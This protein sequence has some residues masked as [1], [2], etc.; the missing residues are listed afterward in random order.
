MEQGADPRLLTS[1]SAIIILG[2][3][4]KL[5]GPAAKLLGPAAKLLGPAAK[6]HGPA[7][8]LLGPEAKR[9][10]LLSM[11]AAVSGLHLRIFLRQFWHTKSPIRIE[12][13][14]DCWQ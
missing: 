1:A 12:R 9:E 14:M 2:S 6:L 13:E 10:R 11:G 4:T 8:K 3:A 7:A 5:L